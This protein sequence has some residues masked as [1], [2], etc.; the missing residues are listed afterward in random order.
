LILIGIPIRA[1][2]NSISVGEGPIPIKTDAPNDVLGK[3]KKY[4]RFTVGYYL[5]PAIDRNFASTAPGK[6]RIQYTIHSNGSVS[7]ITVL[8][9]GNLKPLVDICL[10][11]LKSSVPFKPFDE[12]L[13][14][15]VG[16]KFTDDFN[17]SA[18]PKK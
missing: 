10:A 14:K 13:I 15:Q 4:V 18:L 3:Y 2:S 1:D 17:F 11:S 8:E 6:I 12:A 9:G 5:F 16:E 7:D